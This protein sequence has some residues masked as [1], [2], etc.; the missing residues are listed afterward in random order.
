MSK[1]APPRPRAGQARAFA[2]VASQFNARYVQGLIDHA[3]KEL[4]TLVP[5]SVI[6]LYR[7]SGAFEI[8]VVVRELAIQKSAHAIVAIGVILRGK[9]SHAKNLAHSVTNALQRVA[10]DYGVPVVHAVLSL[11]NER[12]ASERCLKERINRGTEAARA[13]VQIANAISELRGK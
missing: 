5:H 13:A 1:I 8:P 7:V 2:I 10:L 12:Q 11:D 3:T 4:R 9:T 6:S